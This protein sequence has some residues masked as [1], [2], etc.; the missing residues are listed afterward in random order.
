MMEEDVFVNWLDLIDE[1][2]L[3]FWRKRQGKPILRERIRRQKPSTPANH[4]KTNK[5]ELFKR[6]A[7]PK[8]KAKK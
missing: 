2:N 7:K 5:K 1:L 3:V 8:Q 6:F 4:K